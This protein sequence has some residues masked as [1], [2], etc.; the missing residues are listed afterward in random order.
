MK[1]WPHL[2]TFLQVEVVEPTN[3]RAEQSLRH[4]AQW[5]KICFGSQSDDGERYVT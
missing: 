5:R 1:N 3:N 4:A 2:L